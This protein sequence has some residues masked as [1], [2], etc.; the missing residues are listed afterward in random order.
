RLAEL[1]HLPEADLAGLLKRLAPAAGRTPPGGP[2]PSSA[3]P[4]PQ[5][6]DNRKSDVVGTDAPH[7]I[8][9]FQHAERELIGSLLH[10]PRLFHHTL[11]DGRTVAE[12]VVPA[13]MVTDA[14]RR[15][16]QSV[17][18]RLS[19]GTELTLSGLLSDL[20]EHGETALAEL[21]TLAEAEVEQHSQSNE[22]RVK[23]KLAAAAELILR[24]HRDQQH[25]KT[26]AALA[27]QV[28][29]AVSSDGADHAQAEQLQRQFGEYL[30]AHSSPDRI[31]R[32]SGGQ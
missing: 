28:M 32:V 6:A 27:E 8:S 15:L 25:Q 19:E 3:E 24:Y 21:A 5:G 20:A 30:K 31:A 23:A 26:K 22:E 12:A 13:Q 11:S 18:T 10:Q 14:G 16:Y 9:R 4:P 17:Y 7:R 2:T 1:L 29:H